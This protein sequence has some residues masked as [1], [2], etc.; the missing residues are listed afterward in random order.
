MNLIIDG[1][2]L[3]YRTFWVSQN[4]VQFV[5]SKGVDVGCT[6]TF[7]VTFKSLVSN[8]KPNVV[9]VVWDK[10]LEWPS[11]N[12]RQTKTKGQYKGQ[13]DPE[14]H[15]KVHAHENIIVP[16]LDTLG[17]RQMYPRVMEADD[18]IAWLTHNLK[19]QNVIISAD[20]DLLQLISPTTSVFLSTRKQLV[21][22]S[23]FKEVTGVD[24]KHYV[25][26]KAILGDTSDN[27]PGIRGYGPVKAKR[28][29]K[30]GISTL[31]PENQAIITENIKLMSLDIGYRVHTGEV[32]CYQEQ[33][34]K[35]ETLEPDFP[36]F[37]Q[38]CE[39]CEFKSI[40]NKIDTW[41]D[42][43]RPSRLLNILTSYFSDK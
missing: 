7:L 6:Y 16:I 12:F 27:L 24:Q 41:E 2:S 33:L 37:K 11:T 5:T 20:Q 19:D 42:T 31:S 17:V 18:V 36:K 9:Y 32:E 26:Y 10:K 22:Q 35:V 14:V 4:S 39:E 29:I 28:V 40:L 15:K 21:T 38:Y 23:N 34:K 3:L 43:F 8:F 30:D 25:T 13:R 1:S